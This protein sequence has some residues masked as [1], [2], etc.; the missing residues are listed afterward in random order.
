MFLSLFEYGPRL[1]AAV[2]QAR[3]SDPRLEELC[4]LKGPSCLWTREVIPPVLV[5]TFF[6]AESSSVFVKCSVVADLF[7]DYKS[8]VDSFWKTWKIDSRYKSC[9]MLSILLMA[10]SFRFLSFFLFFFF[11]SFP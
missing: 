4:S 8:N 11:F 6:R 9:S 2:A 7:S 3:R 1:Q 5:V 10:H